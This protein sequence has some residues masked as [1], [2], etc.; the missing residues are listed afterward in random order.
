MTLHLS[1]V[2]TNSPI[3][4]SFALKSPTSPTEKRLRGVPLTFPHIGVNDG[5]PHA[6]RPPDGASRCPCP[7]LN[8]LANHSY[9]PHDGLNIT[10]SDIISALQEGMGLSRGFAVFMAIGT[11]T[12][13]RRPSLAPFDLYGASR[14]NFIEHNASM[15]HDDTPP[16]TQYAPSSVD[17]NLLHEFLA[18]AHVTP[19]SHGKEVITQEDIATRRV[20]REAV[21][22]PVD[23]LHA[24]LGRA[25]FAMIMEIFGEGKNKEVVKS[26]METFLKEERLPPGWKPTHICH[27]WEAVARSGKLRNEMN[28]LRKATPPKKEYN[29]SVIEWMTGTV[30]RLASP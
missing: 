21:S 5:G 2:A 10:F 22:G 12:L 18:M 19:E 1:P 29:E 4:E 7:C 6:Y 9:L 23:A 28:E 20:E 30:K 8:T 15:V 14:H 24:E 25:E 27:L 16:D 13:L 11:F 17:L 3:D 26:D